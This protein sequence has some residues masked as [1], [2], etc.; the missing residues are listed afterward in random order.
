[1]S[2][3]GGRLMVHILRNLLLFLGL[4]KFSPPLWASNN[5]VELK[6][7]AQYCT[8]QNCQSPYEQKEI[9]ESSGDTYKNLKHAAIEQAQIWADTILEGDYVADGRTHLD[10]AVAI[11]RDHKLVSYFI[12]YSERAWDV[13]LC[14]YDGLNAATLEG[15]KQ[16]R[17][18]ESVFISPDL[19]STFFTD[20]NY[21]RFIES[22]SF[23]IVN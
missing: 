1:M 11:F 22:G 18:V 7:V 14:H 10:H 6:T 21:A 15:C 12:T 2:R 20:E 13:S 9:T 3:T 16:G 5:G 4:L 23:L 8:L 19:Q 17:I